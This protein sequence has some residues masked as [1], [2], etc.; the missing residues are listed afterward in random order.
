MNTLGIHEIYICN[1][2]NCEFYIFVHELHLGVL[3]K[4]I[5][6]WRLHCFISL[7]FAKMFIMNRYIKCR[8][9]C[10]LPPIRS[11]HLIHVQRTIVIG[12][13]KIVY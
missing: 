13:K 5:T 3:T 7:Y 6:K 4:K 10:G 9:M 8:K 1:S 11:F 12:W 2:E